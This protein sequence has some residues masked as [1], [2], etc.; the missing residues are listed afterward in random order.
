M[1]LAVK[2]KMGMYRERYIAERTLLRQRTNKL[3]QYVFFVHG[4][5]GLLEHVEPK[6]NTKPRLSTYTK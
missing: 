1:L 4:H 2:A 3:I 6:G 5:P